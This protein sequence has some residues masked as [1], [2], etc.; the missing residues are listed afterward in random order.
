MKGYS[1]SREDFRELLILKYNQYSMEELENGCLGI[2]EK[3]SDFLIEWFEDNLPTL[4]QQDDII[5]EYNQFKSEWSKKS[6]TLFSA[7]GAISD[8]FNYEFSYEEIKKIDALSYE[9]GRMPNSWWWVQLA[10]KLVADYWNENHSDLWKV[11]YY[12]IDRTNDLLVN[13]ITD[14]WYTLMTN[15]NGNGK[16]TLDYLKDAVLN[17]TDFW[18][19]TYGHAINVRKVNWKLCVKDSEKGRKTND[20]KKNC[21]IYELEHELSQISCFWTYAYLYTKVR[22][23]ALEE[24]KRLNEFKANLQNAIELNSKMW[25]QTNDKNFQWILHYTNDKLRKKVSDCEEQLKKYV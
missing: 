20:W 12:R 16:Y 5:Y 24:V 14:K 13:N 6:C 9:N 23:D 25:H 21:N 17:G 4:Y 11:A 3:N 22:E 10:V 18:N 7:I 15:Y 1:W 19:S 8:L 2:W